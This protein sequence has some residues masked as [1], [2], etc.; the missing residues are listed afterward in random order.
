MHQHQLSPPSSSKITTINNSPRTFFQTFRTGSRTE[1]EEFMRNRND[2]RK[3]WM[4][5][6]SDLAV[7]QL[8]NVSL[9]ANLAGTCLLYDWRDSVLLLG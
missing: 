7:S 2:E 8:I 1:M 3:D 9:A 6:V 5:V 4:R